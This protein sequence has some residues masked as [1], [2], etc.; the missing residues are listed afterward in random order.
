LH[1]VDEFN[2]KALVGGSDGAGQAG[3]SCTDDGD[4]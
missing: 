3:W 4:I 2:L 1:G